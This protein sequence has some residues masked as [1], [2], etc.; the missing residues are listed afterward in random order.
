LSASFQ[1]EFNPNS[2]TCAEHGCSGARGIILYT[3]NDPEELISRC[4]ENLIRPLADPFIKEEFLVQSRGM[5][6]WVKLQ[7][8]EKLGLFANAQ[9]RFPEETIWM[10]LRG[11]LGAGPEKNPYTKEGMAWK[12]FQLLPSLIEREE[13]AFSQILRYLGSGVGEIKQNADRCF[14]LCRQIAT[15]FD[16]YQTYR[17]KMIMDWKAG[18]LPEGGNRWQGILWLALRKAFGQE[19]LPELM[20]KLRHQAE[21]ISP[22][23]LPHRLSLWGISTFPPIFL[24]VLEHYGRIRPLYVYALQPAPVMWGDV[25]SEKSI[26]KWKSRAINRA[27]EQFGK[28]VDEVELSIEGGNP[29]IGSLGRTGRDF[30][31]LLVDRNAHDH[32]LKFREPT[33]GSL[34]ACLQ[35]WTFDVFSDQPEQR[36]PFTSKDESILV[37]SCHGPMRETEVLRDYILRRFAQDS[38]LRPS[39]ILVMMP[40]PEAYAPYI[41]AT[42]SE[43]ES[44]MPKYLPFSIVDR[45]PR[46]ESHLVDCFFD[47]LEF[48]DGR[49]T[50]RE[51][52]DLIDSSV[53]RKRF[54]LEDEDIEAF[55]LWVSDCHAHWGLT[56][57]HRQRFG[58]VNSDEH[59]WRRALDRMVLGFCMPSHGS[60]MWESILPYD[61]IEGENAQRLGKLSRVID[62]LIELEK[63][64]A[65]EKSL[66]GWVQFL[67][68]LTGKFFPSDNHTLLDRGRVQ[69]A[70]LDLEKEYAPFAED[71][72]VPL[73]VIRYH[74]SNVLDVG[75]RQGQFLTS[76]ITFCGLRS[77][78]SVH[79]RVVC[80]IG[81]N[82]GT[83]P[84][85]TRTPS[86]DLSG[87]RQPGDRSARE[88]DRYLFLE[89]IWCAREYL[90]ISYVGQSI[91]QNQ[92]I[93]PCVVV[94]E[95][96]DSV[97]KL[98][99]F[100][101]AEGTPIKARDSLVR[102]QTLHPFAHNNYTGDQ[103]YRS[104]SLSNLEAAKSLLFPDEKKQA[105][106]TKAMSEPEEKPTE[107]SLEELIR[108]FQCPAEVFLKQRLGMS[109]W[110]EDSPPEECEPF[111]LGSLQQYCIKDHLL[112]IALEL[113]DDVDL[114]ALERANGSLP[115]G[116]LGEVWFHEAKRDIEE[117]VEKWAEELKGEKGDVVLIDQELQGIRLRGELGPLINQR[118]ILYR[119][120]KHIKGKDRVR[121]W[122]Q[123]LFASAFYSENVET[124][125]YSL[126]NNY[127]C[128]Q[129]LSAESAK[130]ELSNLINFYNRG[131]SKP[132]PFFPE[133]SFAFTQ[134][135]ST[136]SKGETIEGK[137][138][139][140]ADQLL[141]VRN[142]WYSNKFHRGEGEASANHL[143][144][145]EEPFERP[146]FKDLA[147]QFYQPFLQA[148]EAQDSQS[149]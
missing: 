63:D 95:L 70:I 40:D 80:L 141:E 74:L 16:S 115:P 25:E 133:S 78:R 77:M 13:E 69:D 125:F 136:Q 22:G 54:E 128:L 97:D 47:L 49:A 51:L 113:N 33:G 108:F 149:E 145:R 68:N 38:T 124:R 10:I 140:P 19:S 142:K 46:Q 6:T 101:E 45:E 117:F 48:F 98:A 50:N 82:D 96:L 11:F 72:L 62:G 102:V 43:M 41:R 67:K 20:D 15:L 129:P 66:L 57:E 84:R 27:S 17:P 118:Q 112:G 86:F 127:L 2:D 55:R 61:L 139:S 87:P 138:S 135:K 75:I 60:R 119:C 4:A 134:S 7:L 23:E 32:P 92:K 131:M 121:S 144:F 36:R 94:N 18:K 110:D 24:D 99:D 14:R 126:A 42:F 81:M 100:G 44:G 143:C 89:T 146:E 52:L 39:D 76:G 106:V 103:N 123:H 58:S 148:S 12:I 56:G 53:F 105:F 59:T 85:Q 8:S 65:T 116:T 73:R 5:S 34:L 37:N 1:Q 83:F 90:Y 26:E 28:Q 93:P 29:L 88:D 107:L 122:I 132:L 147:L 104:Y 130:R 137:K 71:A 64:S 79:S 3:S 9:F 114:L 21:P 30:F 111:D 120:I 91:R 35:R 31:N 109:L